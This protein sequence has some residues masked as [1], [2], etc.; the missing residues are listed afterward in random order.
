MDNNKE[1]I[2]Q[3]VNDSCKDILSFL[4]DKYGLSRSDVKQAVF[5]Y[6]YNSELI[7]NPDSLKFEEPSTDYQ[8]LINDYIEYTKLYMEARR[9]TILSRMA[10]VEQV[11]VSQYKEAT[12]KF[13]VFANSIDKTLKRL[14]GDKNVVRD[15][16]ENNGHNS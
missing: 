7:S 5:F 13:H 12:D 11:C 9:N 1:S 8:N 10:S 15:I 14:F 16:S 6:A 4:A 3:Q 2:L